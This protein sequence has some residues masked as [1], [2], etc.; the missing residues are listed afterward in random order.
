MLEFGN[1]LVNDLFQYVLGLVSIV[2]LLSCMSLVDVV[3]LY[4]VVNNVTGC[5]ADG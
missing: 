4:Q 5:G 3:C 1:D 2:N